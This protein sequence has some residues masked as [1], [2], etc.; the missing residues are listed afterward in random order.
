[1]AKMPSKTITR[2]ID[3][4]TELVVFSPSD[5]ALPCTCKPSTQA[6][7]PITSAMNGALIIPT[8]NVVLETASRSR[9]RKT[10]G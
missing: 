2:K 8:S 7:I 1:M 3:L 9:A 6:T 10:S 5:S 4:T